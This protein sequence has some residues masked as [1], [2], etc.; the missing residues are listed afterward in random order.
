M[1]NSG[2]RSLAIFFAALFVAT[3]WPVYPLVSRIRPF[4]LGLPFALVYVLGLSVVAFVALLWY[5]WRA[6]KDDAS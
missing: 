4:I 3:M 5:D 2:L 6:P 1:G